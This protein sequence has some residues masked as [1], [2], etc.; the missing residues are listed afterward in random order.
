MEITGQSRVSSPIVVIGLFSLIF[1]FKVIF[2]PLDNIVDTFLNT[3]PFLI[4]IIPIAYM[5]IP[6]LQKRVI[7][8]EG[9]VKIKSIILDNTYSH[10]DIR[11]IEYSANQLTVYVDDQEYILNKVSNNDVKTMINTLKVQFDYSE[12]KQEGTNVKIWNIP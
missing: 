12:Q 8:T 4:G 7:I 1:I 3:T 5:I 6:G 2:S 10:D 9:E 11:R